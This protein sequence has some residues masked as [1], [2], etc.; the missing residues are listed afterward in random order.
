M[1]DDRPLIAAAIIVKNEADHL[2]RCLGS[3]RDFCDE[4]VV[5]DTGSTDDTVAIAESFGAKVLHKPWR[6]DFAA[7][8]NFALDAV[9][10]EWVLYIDADEELVMK[11]I[12]AMRAV[13]RD[14]SNVMAFGLRMHTQANWTP[15]HDYRMWRH[16]DDIRFTGEIHE[17]TM[18]DIMRVARETS[19]V[20]Q[21]TV[22]NILHHG[23][24]GDLTAKH[25]RNLPLLLAELKVHP[26]KINLWNHLGRV[27]LALGRPDLAEQA[28][29]TGI[30]R[31]ER[32]GPL[33]RFDV[34]V[35]GSLADYLIASGRD[36]QAILD[37]GRELDPTFKTFTWLQVRQ[38]MRRG[39]FEAALAGADELLAIGRDD[40]A[41]DGT[42]YNL[43][44][45]DAWPRTARIDCLFELMRF[46]DVRAEIEHHGEVVAT[47]S[48]R[49]KQLDVCDAFDV[50]RAKR[51]QGTRVTPRSPIPLPDVAFV[52]PVRVETADR[53]ANVLA[54]TRHITA[55][56]DCRVVL[57][58]EQPE[59]L[60]SIVPASVDVIGVD[61]SPDHAFHATRVLNDVSRHVDAPI[62]IHCDTDTLIPVEQLLESVEQIRRGDADVVLPFSFGIG[63]LQSERDA[64]AAGELELEGVVRPRPMVGIPTGLCQV[65]SAAAF[66]RAGMENERLI[67]WAPDDAER[68]ER[69]AILEMRVERVPGPAF[70]MD[71][72]TV[73]GRDDAS[74]FHA[75]SQTERQRILA[76]S[77]TE[78]EADIESWPWRVRGEFRRP[79]PFDASDLTVLIPVRIDTTDRL[80]NLVTCTRAM[81]NTMNCRI[82]VGIGDQTQVSDQLDPRVEVIS[83]HDPAHQ[84]FHRTRIINE[85]ATKATTDRVA[86]VDTDVVVPSRQWWDALEDLRHARADMVYPYDGRMV[87][88]PWASHSW[89]ERGDFEALGPDACQ[90]IETRSVGGCFVMERASFLAYGLENERFISWG[91]EDDERLLRAH[92]L[93]LKVTRM[94]GVI[95]HVQHRR[96][97]DSR[98]DNPHVLKNA[99]ELQR[100]KDLSDARLRAEVDGWPWKTTRRDVKVLI[101]NDL[102]HQDP[103]IVDPLDRGIEL[104]RDRSRL[105]DCDV[106]VV[107]LPMLNMDDIPPPS[108]A[109]RVL[110]TREA[111]AHVPGI[112]EEA[113][114]SRFDLIASHRRG[115][116]LWSP[117][118]PVGLLGDLPDIVPV[119]E[120]VPAV[121]SAWIS[122][123]WDASGRV[124]LLNEL[125]LHMQVD[126]Y[127][128][129][130]KNTG[131]Q[132]VRSHADRWRIASRY[133]FVLA[134]EN[135]CEHDYVTEKFFDPLIFGAV[136]VYL[137]A[138]NVADFAPGEHCYIDASEFSSARELAEFLMSMSDDEYLRYHGWRSQ[139]RRT[140]FVS[141]CEGIPPALLSPLVQSIRDRRSP[142]PVR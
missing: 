39:E 123:D 140:E 128:R 129:V 19:R 96:G 23:Y 26:E 98:P 38:H 27:H 37:R 21:P 64:F 104:I 62:R 41:D 6:D 25:R 95:Y 81:L 35:Y 131:D 36:A 17:S 61:G 113:V 125:M 50:W 102:W 49:D 71:H 52:I 77:R 9:T 5:V 57:G 16:R 47:G 101:W 83:I 126:S 117:Y 20:L 82:L 72:S 79:E 87:E 13:V 120:R 84:A 136:P 29:R 24:E 107:G 31:I 124:Q 91:Y 70:H 48:R 1:T 134:F 116:G 7:S 110:L 54:L 59:S 86:V 114:T 40:T 8:R 142:I 10:A 132:F 93:G 141:L 66:E 121:A 46:D 76:M 85:L 3:I 92:K 30:E 43:D 73:A 11:D 105:H 139:P 100:I 68:L 55:T 111:G 56:Y 45:F 2:R 90:L 137:G 119:D 53:L 33:T 97:P 22:I 94:T 122:S 138:P 32:V 75:I 42:A 51:K 108:K 67:G 14:A 34:H 127:G 115:S 65:W 4:I 88:V 28:W 112:D 133:R 118:V 60:R 103:Q 18:G 99:T 63:V 78:L 58:C 109:T 106:V 80:R 74:D 89:L 15:Y 12:H 44:M 135:A 130:A 69:L